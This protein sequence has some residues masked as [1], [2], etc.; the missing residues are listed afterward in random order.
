MFVLAACQSSPSD[1]P[2]PAQEAAPAKP[3]PV[4]EKPEKSSPDADDEAEPR[5]GLSAKIAQ[6]VE[7]AKAVPEVFEI[8]PLLPEPEP[9]FDEPEPPPPRKYAPPTE[10]ELRAWDRKDPEG[11]KHL[12]RWDED[13]RALLDGYFTDLQCF[14]VEMVEAGEAYV[15]GGA[16]AEDVW[17]EFKRDTIMEIDRWQRDLFVSNPRITE[18]SKAL[19]QILEMHEIVMINYP[20]AYNSGDPTEIS[21]TEAHWMIVS[22]KA[23]LYLT[24]V[25]GTMPKPSAAECK[26][27]AAAEE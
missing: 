15:A 13:N 7:D 10:A 27:R 23:D 2:P 11:E 1:E 24:K 4:P 26:A 25:G 19:G 6:Q 18:K 5:P 22:S 3:E 20:R 21:K 12:Y 8:A 17:F 9:E 16:D 14:R